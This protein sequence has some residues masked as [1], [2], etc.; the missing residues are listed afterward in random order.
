MASISGTVTNKHAWIA[1]L[2][3]ASY[4]EVKEVDVDMRVNTVAL[5]CLGTTSFID[6]DSTSQ[7]FDEIAP[8]QSL[9]MSPKD[10][11]DL[12]NDALK[13]PMEQEYIDAVMKHDPVEGKSRILRDEQWCLNP[14]SY[15]ESRKKIYEK[16]Y[17]FEY[18]TVFQSDYKGFI[19]V[20]IEID[21]KKRVIDIRK[22]SFD[23]FPIV[24]KSELIAEIS[25]RFP[26]L[27]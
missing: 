20:Y 7:A 8:E 21:N 9:D 14:G 16:R 5:A 11:L 27:T 23:S 3:H 19:K 25:R 13:T 4:R 22:E 10:I 1:I 18:G 26:G 24:Y 17:N 2:S 6:I 15:S 12:F